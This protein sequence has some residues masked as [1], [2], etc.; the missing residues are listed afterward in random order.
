MDKRIFVLGIGLFV[1]I[2]IVLLCF[3]N[4][5]DK[6]NTMNDYYNDYET[7]K[8]MNNTRKESLRSNASII[9]DVFKV[10]YAEYQITSSDSF[11]GLSLED[12]NSLLSGTPQSLNI[13]DNVSDEFNIVSKDYNLD[14]SYVYFDKDSSRFIVCLVA[15]KNGSLYVEEA[16]RGSNVTVENSPVK[17]ELPANSMWACS[18]NSHSWG[19]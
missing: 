19:D 11:L 18:D 2:C 17:A 16:V 10:K 8:V 1:I 9:A 15:E 14:N 3:M 7:V 5:D 4:D 6:D 12:S 13:V